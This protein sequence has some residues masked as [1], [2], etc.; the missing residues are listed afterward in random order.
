MSGTGSLFRR[1]NTWWD[2]YYYRG[3]RFRE[4]ARSPLKK[5]ATALLKRRL[6]EMSR[7]TLIGPDQEALAFEDIAGFIETDYKV[8][9]RKS[10]RR[11][12]GAFKHLKR[13]IGKLRA[14]DI[15]TDRITRYIADRKEEGGANSTIRKETAAL[16]RM[17]TL[18]VRANRL[19]RSPHV[20]RPV[21]RNVREHFLSVGD[22]NE[23]VNRLPKYLGPVVLF[24][25]YPRIAV[26]VDMIATRHGR[27]TA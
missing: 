4:S 9:E 1:G 24:D 2:S 23:V 21:V 19:S 14:I 17:F 10:A 12:R 6:A 13:H 8:N 11:L 15:P 22:V 26:T 3:E 5:D 18:A 20:P 25:Y 27:K 16:K 7:G